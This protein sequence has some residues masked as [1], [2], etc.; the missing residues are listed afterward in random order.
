LYLL[1]ESVQDEKLVVGHGL[2]DLVGHVVG[3]LKNKTKQNH[4]DY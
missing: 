4:F 2:V 1:E 3:G